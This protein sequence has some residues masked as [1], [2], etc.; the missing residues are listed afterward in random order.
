[1]QIAWIAKCDIHRYKVSL[2]M[3][4]CASHT[5]RNGTDR[6]L[7]TEYWTH[8]ARGDIWLR[9]EQHHIFD[10]SCSIGTDR[11]ILFHLNVLLS[12]C[13]MPAGR[14]W[15]ATEKYWNHCSM[16]THM[17]RGRSS[18][19]TLCYHFGSFSVCV[20]RAHGIICS[21]CGIC[22]NPWHHGRLWIVL[23]LRG[24]SARNSS[25]SS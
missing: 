19:N 22:I 2:D 15:I 8:M 16:L 13:S 11:L 17:W 6:A 7:S 5:S 3:Y 20:W 4:K 24:I 10:A 1:M 14:H 21:N 18:W 12:I 25:V 23:L 9:Q